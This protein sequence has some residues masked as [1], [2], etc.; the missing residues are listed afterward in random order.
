M[1]LF[2][3]WLPCLIGLQV[4]NWSSLGR[5]KRSRFPNLGGGGQQFGGGAGAGA[6]SGAPVC[7]CL[8][9]PS[10]PQLLLRLSQGTARC[11]VLHACTLHSPTHSPLPGPYLRCHVVQLWRAAC[12]AT[13]TWLPATLCT[14]LSTR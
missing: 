11:Q 7:C 1:L 4:P 13:P 6:L 5:L 3:T 14:R 8:C 12:C 2:I 9:V 10:L